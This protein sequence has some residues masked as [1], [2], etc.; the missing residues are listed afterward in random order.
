MLRDDILFSYKFSSKFLKKHIPYSLVFEPGDV[1]HCVE[2][3]IKSTNKTVK[4]SEVDHFINNFSRNTIMKS[5]AAD[6]LK[7]SKT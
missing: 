4:K 1:D 2:T 6:L 3:I 5:F 7:I